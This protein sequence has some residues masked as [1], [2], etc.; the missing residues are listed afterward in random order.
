MRLKYPLGA[1][2]S[3][4][5][6]PIL[7]IQG[8][9]VKATIPKL[10]EATGTE[11][12]AS[13]ST[14]DKKPFQLLTLGE[15]TIAGVG[16]ETHALGFTGTLAQSLA[17]MLQTDVRW[18]VYAKS[19]Y[20]AKDVQQKFLPQISEETVD[21]VVIGLGANDAFAL[22]HPQRWRKDVR[23]LILQ[24]QE[25][26]PTAPIFFCNMPPIKDFPAFTPQMK[27]VIGNLV[28]ILGEE[29]KILV[30]EMP[31]VYYEGSVI[32]IL[33]WGRKLEIQ[34]PLAAFFSDGV[35]PSTFA[36]QVW[37]RETAKQILDSKALNPSSLKNDVAPN[38][39]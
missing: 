16:V 5:L 21:L 1:L 7:Y 6:L 20:T 24:I 9:K 22:H 30:E 19:G 8:A 27:F 33:E 39:P 10:P 28:E 36:Y 23:N 18:K 2:I 11:G 26:Y 38:T 3:L 31:H 15:S 34:D 4:P 35:H 13:S 29:L 12:M 17:E 25:M 14:S 32:S 37:A